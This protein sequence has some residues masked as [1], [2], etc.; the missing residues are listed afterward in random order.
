ME[1]EA[2]FMGDF[3]IKRFTKLNSNSK[4]YK[5]DTAALTMI[6]NGGFL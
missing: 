6:F 5:N 4:V 2:S 1:E 3:L